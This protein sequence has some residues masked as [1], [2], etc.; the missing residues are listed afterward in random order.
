MGADKTTPKPK[1]KVGRP[2]AKLN[3]KEVLEAIREEKCNP[4]IK[5]LSVHFK[6]SYSTFHLFYSKHPEIK[7]ALETVQEQLVDIAQDNIKD[8][9]LNKGD[10]NNFA[11]S[12][13]VLQVLAP[14]FKEKPLE[15]EHKGDINI[16]IVDAKDKKKK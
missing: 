15:V 14:K 11:A 7:E 16:N 10:F 6:V 9:L 5:A 13:W 12:K 1:R 8:I 3:L 2:K 4:S